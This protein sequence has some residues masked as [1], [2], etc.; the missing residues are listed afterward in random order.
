MVTAGLDAIATNLSMEFSQLS[1]DGIFLAQ[2]ISDPNVIGQMQD[3]FNN[4]IVSGQVWA[5]A[6]GFIIGYV[7]RGLTAS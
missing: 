1:L 3:A 5:L 7:V 6:I 4:F 2:Q